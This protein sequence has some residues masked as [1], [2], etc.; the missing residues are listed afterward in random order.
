MCL[1][2]GENAGKAYKIFQKIYTIFQSVGIPWQNCASLSVDNTNA[3]VGKRSSFG[4]RF[5]DKNPN[6]YIGGYPYHLAHIVASNA[7]DVFSKFMGLNFEDVYVDCYYW[8]ANSTKCKG[9][10]L[11][12]FHFCDQ[13]YQAVLNHLSLRWLSL[14]KCAV[15]VLKKV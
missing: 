11:A 15:R 13:E 9:K 6:V 4:S 12:Y 14:E 2:D 10:L 1:T 5:L 7:N 3:M 8:F